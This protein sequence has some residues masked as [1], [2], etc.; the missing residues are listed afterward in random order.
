MRNELEY[1]ELAK[2]NIDNNGVGDPTN[3]LALSNASYGLAKILYIQDYLGFEQNAFF[4]SAPDFTITRNNPRWLSGFSYGGMLIWGDGNVPLMILD[5]RPNTC[6]ILVGGFFELP[7]LSKMIENIDSI[8]EEQCPK[9]SL[10]DFTRR[11]HFFTIFKTTNTSKKDIYPY[12]FFL[13]GNPDAIKRDSEDLPG[14]YLEKSTWL[15]QNCTRIETPFGNIHILLEEDAKYYLEFY[16]KHEN[17]S[18]IYREKTAKSI[19][20]NYTPIS[21]ETHQGL[22]NLNQLVLGCYLA[23]MKTILPFSISM[24]EDA[25]LITPKITMQ[26]ILKSSNLK[27]RITDLFSY[28]LD[29]YSLLPH[30]SGYT[31]PHVKEIKKIKMINGKRYYVLNMGKNKTK[32]IISNISEIPFEYRRKNGYFNVLEDYYFNIHS[33][34]RP[35]YSFRV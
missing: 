1:L 15:Q 27:K 31:T 9:G 11:N 26:E 30:G 24:T 2:R 22:V 18:R 3:F 33:T 5:P 29:Q 8:I 28:S 7:S 16:L 25:Y 14:L 23:P 13:H 21:N 17:Y 4:I 12:I 34:L 20:G 10:W 35:I 19:L 6:G 32:L